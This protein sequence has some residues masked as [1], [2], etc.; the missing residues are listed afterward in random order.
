METE[1]APTNPPAPSA[2][3][4]DRVESPAA[5][6]CAGCKSP[7]QGVYFT[8]NNQIICARC[9]DGLMAAIN[10]GSPATHFATAA[11]YGLG[12]GIAGAGLWYAVRKLTGV[13]LG[14]IAIVLGY[15]VGTAIRKASKGRGGIPYQILAIVIT[16]TCIAGQWFPDF[17]A[18]YTE[19][20]PETPAAQVAIASAMAA[21]IWPIQ[22]GI[23]SII[24][25]VI[26]GFALWEAWKLNRKGTLNITGPH[27]ITPTAPPAPAP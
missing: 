14:L 12:G 13:P 19:S 25:L 4:F 1:P 24:G 16:Y 20:H 22:R 27:A 5:L 11:V 2:L 8:V 26:I 17:Y 9:R 18:F 23:Q 7:I 21:F 10:S 15:L 3:Q 6:A